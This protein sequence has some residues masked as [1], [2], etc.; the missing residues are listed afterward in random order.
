MK[1][2]LSVFFPRNLVVPGLTEMDDEFKGMGNIQFSFRS[3]FSNRVVARLENLADE[4]YSPGLYQ[5]LSSLLPRLSLACVG[6]L[7]LLA[8][9]LIFVNGG[10]DSNI[11]FG[12]ET[13]DDSNFIS[14]LI[15]QK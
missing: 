13:I 8:G 12:T 3:G 14:Y 15:I 2:L 5:G 1:K 4:E 10:L 6:I 11:L 9:I 7:V